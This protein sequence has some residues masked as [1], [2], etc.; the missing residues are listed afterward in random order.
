LL[1]LDSFCRF[2]RT[3]FLWK[4]NQTLFSQSP[5]KKKKKRSGHARLTFGKVKP[6]IKEDDKV[7]QTTTI[8]T[9]IAS[10]ATSLLAMA[11]NATSLLAMAFGM[12]S[13]EDCYGY[14]SHSGYI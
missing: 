8:S 14:I 4:G 13:S 5:T 11:S 7:F 9:T 6:I 10:N 2:H 3:K 1:T 12:V